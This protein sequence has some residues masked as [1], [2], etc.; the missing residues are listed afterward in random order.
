LFGGLGEE[1]A[2]VRFET[3][4]L[5]VNFEI[6]VREFVAFEVVRCENPGTVPILDVFGDVKV[7][8]VP[9]SDSA[10][11]FAFGFEVQGLDVFK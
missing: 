8:K 4:N 10:I 7:D 5:A 1:L 11:F 6:L 2:P 9:S 3:V